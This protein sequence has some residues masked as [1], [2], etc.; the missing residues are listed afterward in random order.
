[1]LR[2][3]N[4]K[5]IPHDHQRYETVGDYWYDSEGILQIRVSDVGDEMY[6]KLVVIHELVEEAI[7]KHNGI[8]EQQIMDFDLYYEARRKQGFVPEDSEAGFDT[9]APYRLAH[10]FATGVELGICAMANID[11]NEYDKKLNSL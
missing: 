2:E 4:I 3:I 9:N 5:V 10:S 6:H 11:W 1:M 8:S 7:T